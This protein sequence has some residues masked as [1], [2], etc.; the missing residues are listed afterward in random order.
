MAILKE[1]DATWTY[2]PDTGVYTFIISSELGNPIREIGSVEGIQNVKVT[3]SNEGTLMRIEIHGL[4]KPPNN[5]WGPEQYY[6]TE[7]G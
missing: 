2:D 6:V 3:V 1:K 5:P 7:D 4:P